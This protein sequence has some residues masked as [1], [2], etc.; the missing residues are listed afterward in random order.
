[1]AYTKNFQSGGGAHQPNKY[2]YNSKEEQEMPGKFL[3]YG[4]R[5]YDAQ[6]GRWHVI[7]PMIEKHYEWTGYAYVY[8]NPIVLIDPMGLDSVYFFDQAQNPNDRSVYTAEVFHV[9]N[10][11]LVGGE[12][13]GSTYPNYPDTRSGEQNTVANGEHMFDNKSGH[14]IGS[15]KGLN[16]VNS[17]GDR[18]V[19]GAKPDG[20]PTTMTAVNIH[21]GD[22][23][24]NRGSAGC[25]TIRPSDANSFLSNFDWSGNTA[26]TTGNS[27]GKVF[28]IRGQNN[29]SNNYVY[30][31]LKAKQN[32]AIYDRK[33][34]V[35]I[36][37]DY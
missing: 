30:N 29:P 28:I 5:M 14:K 33:R 12:V 27:S 8:N 24:T 31:D 6:L 9:K 35:Y 25:P 2:L 32:N 13:A 17:E 21:A 36:R 19:S 37:N 26:Q 34:N 15:E 1:M 22:T 18:K 20:T 11:E 16:M 4:W 23:E 3:D 10:G 7:D